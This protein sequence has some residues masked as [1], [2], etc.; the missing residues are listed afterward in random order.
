MD[1]TVQDKIFKFVAEF[2]KQQVSIVGPENLKSI[3]GHEHGV[4]PKNCL[5]SSQ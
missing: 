5:L 4:R 2:K 1:H 3:S